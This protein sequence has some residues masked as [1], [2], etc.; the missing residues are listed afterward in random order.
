MA[1]TETLPLKPASLVSQRSALEEPVLVR[2]LLIGIAL[3][4]L[5]LF[6]FVPLAAVFTEAFRA[7]VPAYLEAI[8]E[9][10]ARAAIKLTLLVA[11]IAVP[12][13]MAFGLIAAWAIG[14]FEFR[15]KQLLITLIDIPFA[16]S[17][18]ISGLIYVLLFG[19]QGWLGPWLRSQELQI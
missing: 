8:A 6:L 3:A 4:F 5:G 9:P 19:L 15:G 12:F 14:K 18:V 10:D 7:G 11:A 17:P 16:V 1:D 13:N 2:R